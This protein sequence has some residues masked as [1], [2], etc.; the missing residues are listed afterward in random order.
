MFWKTEKTLGFPRSL[1]II[2]ASLAFSTNLE[3]KQ[4]DWNEAESFFER[5]SRF[6][7]M[8]DQSVQIVVLGSIL[9]GISCGLIGS[10]VVTRRLS[11]FGDTLSHAVLPGIAIGF[12]WSQSKDNLALLIGATVAGFSGVTCLTLLQKYTPIRQDSALGI[13]LSGFYAI[14]IC[15]LTRIQKMEFGNQSGLDS[16]LFGQASAL[17][18]NDLW[19]IGITLAG[20]G[21]FILATH[22]ELLISGFDP[23]FARS[24]GIYTMLLQYGLWILLA[25]C[26]ITSLQV[27]GVILASALLIIPAATASLLVKRMNAY[28]FLASLLG[29]IAGLG[30]TFLSFL[31]QGLPTGPLIVLVSTF[32]FLLVLGFRPKTGIFTLWSY[33]RT[34]SMRIKAENTL[35]AVYHILESQN[36]EK[37]S[38]TSQDL[39]QRVG[40]G[41]G[42]CD[43]EIQLLIRMNL[44]TQRSTRDSSK[45]PGQSWITLTPEGWDYAC[46]IVRNHRLWE[47]YLTNEAEYAPDHVHEDAEKI[48]HVLGDQ[49]IRQLERILSNPRE[50]PHGKL[51]PSLDDMEHGGIEKKYGAEE[52]FRSR[53]QT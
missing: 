26:I 37:T 35:K 46:K 48:E 23:S 19:G 11:L 45:L 12:I 17:S 16:F 30:G 53:N 22:K 52:G 44:A 34:H 27:I 20:I 8:Q 29:G 21:L 9:I 14:G 5:T 33:S 15:L 39:M 38:I 41:R 4:I 7:Q 43:R 13:V 24:I 40:I 49:T 25:F 1:G 3:A 50:D 10:Y 42:D 32:L 6:W 18:I 36:F 31:G 51:I 28:L 47:L 2:T